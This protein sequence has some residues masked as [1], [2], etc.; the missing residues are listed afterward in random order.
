MAGAKGKLG[1]V[2]LDDLSD[3]I[4]VEQMLLFIRPKKK[5]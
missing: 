5:R 4:S 3:P 1:D 2:N